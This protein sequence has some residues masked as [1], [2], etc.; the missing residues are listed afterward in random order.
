MNTSLICYSS[1]A[2]DGEWPPYRVGAAYL[3]DISEDAKRQDK[4]AGREIA[5]WLQYLPYLN[6]LMVPSARTEPLNSD[7]G[8]FIVKL[9]KR[10]LGDVNGAKKMRES[11]YLFKK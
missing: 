1:P 3:H 10:G 2:S 6:N 4:S 8:R 5:F 7:R 9:I 11:I